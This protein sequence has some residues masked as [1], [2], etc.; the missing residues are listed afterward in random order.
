MANK[1][2]LKKSAV[3]AKVPLT[4]DLDYGELAINYIDEKIYFK[5]S[6]NVIK[7]F[8]A[9]A[10]V[11]SVSGTGTVSGL[12][13]TGTVTT[14]GSL[15]LGGTLSLGSLN[16][17]GTAAGLST[18]LAVT[19]GGTGL[20]SLTAGYIPYGNGTSALSSNSNLYFSGTNLGVGTV[21]PSYNLQVNGSFAATSKSFLI[22]HPTKE[23]MKLC[24]G[25]LESPYHGV[26]LTGDDTLING[27][28]TV[29]LPD[30]IHK[31]CKQEGSQVQI[32][33]IKHGKVIWVDA[34]D[35][36]NNIFSVECKTTVFDRTEYRFYWAFTGIR[37]DV[38]DLVVEF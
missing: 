12:T 1:V 30:Y 27:K 8:I 18:T 26:R 31:L 4:T 14:T 33:N 9:G 29:Q 34:V 23:G 36:E 32:T 3:S 16:T 10:S 20:T 21:T 7:S 35:V 17:L 13:L 2:L 19:S 22:E 25:S 38:E 15:T 11:S 5:N 37:K 28:C 24:Y 6:T